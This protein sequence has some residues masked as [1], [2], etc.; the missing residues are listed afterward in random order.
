MKAYCIKSYLIFVQNWELSILLFSGSFFTTTE[1]S[2][3][4]TEIVKMD[5]TFDKDEF[6]KECERE[7]IPNVLEVGSSVVENNPI[8]IFSYDF[9]KSS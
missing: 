7:I 1:M 5:P 9:I 2:E 8:L 3:V 4:L 6:I